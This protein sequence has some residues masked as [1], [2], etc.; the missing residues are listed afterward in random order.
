M[1]RHYAA[2]DLATKARPLDVS[3]RQKIIQKKVPDRRCGRPPG[4]RGRT[5]SVF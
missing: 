5:V 1:P 4:R 3:E 2:V